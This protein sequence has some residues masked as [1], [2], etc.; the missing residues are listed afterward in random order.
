MDSNQDPDLFTL[1]LPETTDLARPL[2]EILPFQM[3]TLAMA[4]R[5]GIEAGQFRYVGKV[6]DRE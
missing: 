2:V 1:L 4:K 6:T 5:K 3:L